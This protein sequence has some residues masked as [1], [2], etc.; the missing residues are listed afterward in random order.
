MKSVH[1]KVRA[2]LAKT[3]DVFDEHSVEAGVGLRIREK[4]KAVGLSLVEL[5]AKSGL[6]VGY[7]SQ[8]ERGLSS[9]TLRALTT[10]SDILAVPLTTL[11]SSR[12]TGSQASTMIVRKARSHQLT[13][14]GSGIRKAALAGRSET[15]GLAF[16]MSRMTLVPGADSGPDSYVHEGYEA[17]YIETGTIVLTIAGELHVLEE[18]D[19]FQFPS[20]LPHRFQN[21][22]RKPA[23]I[24][25]L[26]LK[27]DH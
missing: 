24:V 4:R 27:S 9:A 3:S 25:M 15:G 12:P 16:T 22:H 1:A 23:V 8:L 14:W 17:G 5:S 10:L 20:V 21:S 18:G 19:S 11:L 7:L 26:N 13:M 6:S 2:P